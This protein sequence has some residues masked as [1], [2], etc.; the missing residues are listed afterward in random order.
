MEMKGAGAKWNIIGWAGSRE[1][2]RPLSPEEDS[3]AAAGQMNGGE[4]D[5]SHSSGAVRVG[6]SSFPST[7]MPTHDY[8]SKTRWRIDWPPTAGY[9][10]G[11]ACRDLLGRRILGRVA[12]GGLSVGE[13]Q[14]PGVNGHPQGQSFESCPYWGLDEPCGHH[15]G[16]PCWPLKS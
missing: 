5:E 4:A 7:R 3:A 12:R 9:G 2:C 10:G 16:P 14:N 8:L 1:Q 11:N 13:V 15:A 6:V